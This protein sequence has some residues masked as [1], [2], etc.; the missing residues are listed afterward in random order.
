MFEADGK[1][2]EVGGDSGG[3]ELVV[4]EL[5]VG[6]GGGVQEAGAGVGDV[7]EDGAEA[8]GV[9]EF[10]GGGAAALDAEGDDAAG[11]AG[12]VFLGEGVVG[13]GGEAGVVDPGDAGVVLQKF[14]D[15]Q[16]VAD[17]A[18]HAQGQGLEAEVEDVGGEG[19][20]GGAEVAHELGA[21]LDDVISQSVLE[22]YSSCCSL[23]VYAAVSKPVINLTSTSPPQSLSY[24]SA[25][26][27][28]ASIVSSKSIATSIF[29]FVDLPTISLT[30][31]SAGT[32]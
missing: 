7:G 4:G 18:L 5:A 1:A 12:H 25:M 21:G 11:S 32:G 16:G 6:G 9:H 10:G 20:L 29:I 14:G 13:A 30:L 26:T 27:F 8:H 28:Q 2:D 22:L 3:G 15:G 24:S 31:L 19:R 17:V 23:S